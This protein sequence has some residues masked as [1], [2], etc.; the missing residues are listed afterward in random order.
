M[1][2]GPTSDRLVI[3]GGA[4]LDTL[5][6]AG[7]V[8]RS[9]GGAGLYTSLAAARAGARVVMVGPRPEPMPTR[10]APAAARI[11]WRGPRVTPDDLPTFEIAHHSDGRTEMVEARLRAEADLGPADLPVDLAGEL[12]FLIAMA[13]P[14]Q[15]LALLEE[16]MKRGCRVA[17][18]AYMCAVDK[19]PETV[20]RIFERAD[21]F[22]C[23]QREAEGL[24]GDLGAAR[25][26]PGRLLF[27]TRGPRGARVVQGD[28]ATDVA[29]VE[30]RELDPTGA[31]D[32]FSGT[33]L[34]CLQRGLHP[35]EA[36]R[37]GVAAAAEMVTR[38]GPEALLRPPPPPPPPVDP[39]ARVDRRRVAGLAPVVRRLDEL[40]PYP[41]VGPHL[42]SSGDQGALDFFFAATA[43]QFGFWET[44]ADRYARPMI[45][46]LDGHELKGSDYLWACYLR[47]L[48]E[49]PGELTPEGQ[50]GLDLETLARRLRDDRG[51]VPLPALQ[52][53]LRLANQQG[54]DLLALG[55]AP[56]AILDRANRARRPL[57]ALLDQLDHVGGYKEDPLRKKSALLALI[58]RQRPE[59]FLRRV[60]GDA[61]PPIVDYHVQRS[62]L[63]TGI[64]RLE[65][66]DLR[67]RLEGRRLLNADDEWAVRRASYDA[68]LALEAASG[69]PMEVVDQLF[70]LNRTHCPEMTEP[71]CPA[72]PLEPACARAK[73]LFQPVRRT[74]F[75]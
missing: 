41:F 2:T 57:A 17:C 40:K 61:V 35:V 25:T 29:G 51:E 8:A 53:R 37:R 22:F 27:I 6:F 50:A 49:A 36:A 43:Q 71:D 38:V 3:V 16:L 75:Y 65:D 33:T 56:A 12:V 62:C 32:T 46:R 59:G 34:A 28:H 54:R 31:G 15:Q 67:R 19:R 44:A 10:L 9:A 20:R 66:G 30:V 45:A 5:R 11:D 39:R 24:F 63:R 73:A 42:P 14:R 68:M 48:G 13:E 60:E 58:L 4:S 55:S 74:T 23:N 70:F 52:A 64:V 72:C 69:R 26:S 21:V 1:V 7:R 18:G 47:W